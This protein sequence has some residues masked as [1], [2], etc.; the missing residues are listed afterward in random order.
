MK[1]KCLSKTAS[2]P[3]SFPDRY[4]YIILYRNLLY[5]SIKLSHKNLSPVHS[6][7]KIPA[8]DRA[9]YIPHGDA[10]TL[11]EAHNVTNAVKYTA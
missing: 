6:Y 3:I 2:L 11:R 5:L 7:R 8:Q 10:L 1:M 9:G 4:Y